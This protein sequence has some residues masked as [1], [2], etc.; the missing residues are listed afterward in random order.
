MKTKIWLYILLIY[1]PIHPTA[2]KLLIMYFPSLPPPVFS[3]WQDCII[4]SLFG[5]GIFQGIKEPK[6]KLITLDYAIFLWL[7]LSLPSA[8]KSETIIPAIYGFRLTYLPVLL[9]FA[10]RFLPLEK[11]EDYQRLVNTILMVSGFIALSGIVLYY[12]VPFQYIETWYALNAMPINYYQDIRRMDSIFWSPVVFGALMATSATLCYSLLFETSKKSFSRKVY[13]IGII[14]FSYCCLYT[15]SRGSW[16]A[17]V[18]GISIISFVKWRKKLGF[19]TICFLGLTIVITSL[20]FLTDFDNPWTKHLATII[21]NSE[22]GTGQIEREEQRNA[23]LNDIFKNILFGKGLGSS[24][25]VGAWFQNPVGNMDI[26]VADN[27][28]IKVTQESGVI[29]LTIFI[30]FVILFLSYVFKNYRVLTPSPYRDLILGI[31][32]AFIGFNIQGYGSNVW[33]FYM[34]GFV[35]WLMIAI[36]VNIVQG[37]SAKQT[38]Q[39]IHMELT[40]PSPSSHY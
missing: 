34:V 33:D 18:T 9:Y 29:G 36:T 17:E 16:I 6:Y 40:S 12:F 10:V 1:Y 35:Y 15:L 7:C 32:A 37:I 13:L 21:D 5:C 26:V 2:Y 39:H 30:I 38:M 11:F 31:G 25:H 28:Y 20:T 14:L 23:G 4:L 19:L 27:W 8:I 3:V 22:L 24:G